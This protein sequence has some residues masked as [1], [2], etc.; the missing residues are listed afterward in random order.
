MSLWQAVRESL[1]ASDL[2][3]ARVWLKVLLAGLLLALVLWSMRW[4]RRTTED[5]W[6]GRWVLLATA[7]WLAYLLAW[8]GFL[9]DVLPPVLGRPLLR[10]GLELLWALVP[11]FRI[12]LGKR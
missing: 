10:H 6:V 3:E 12:A 11:F 8:T 7:T 5:D 1:R 2:Y 4:I 9:D